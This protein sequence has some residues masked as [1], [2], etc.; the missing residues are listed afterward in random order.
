MLTPNKKY[1]KNNH[2]DML[3][4]IL[5]VTHLWEAAH[6][7]PNRNKSFIAAPFSDCDKQKAER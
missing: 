3:K 5:F 4:I 7:T 1:I 2:F 6:K